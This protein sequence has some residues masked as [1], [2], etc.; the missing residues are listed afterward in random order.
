MSFPSGSDMISKEFQHS[1]SIYV[2]LM[3]DVFKIIVKYRR[4]I[5]AKYRHLSPSG[6]RAL[7]NIFYFWR[8]PAK[9]AALR[10]EVHNIRKRRNTRNYKQR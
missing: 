3:T 6:N 10:K 5:I 7:I 1:D 9:G 4:E 8:C 2:N